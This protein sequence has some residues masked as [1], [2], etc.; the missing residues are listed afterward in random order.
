MLYKAP[1]PRNVFGRGLLCSFVFVSPFFFSFFFQ[2]RFSGTSSRDGFKGRSC[3]FE[4][5]FRSIGDFQD[6]CLAQTSSFD[7]KSRGVHCSFGIGRQSTV[8]LPFTGKSAAQA[9]GAGT[10]GL[11]IGRAAAPPRSEETRPGNISSSTCAHLRPSFPVLVG[12]R[13]A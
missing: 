6:E 13:C 7:L 9:Q 11:C 5:S 4:G 2:G 8:F 1:R 3:L 12:D 10:K